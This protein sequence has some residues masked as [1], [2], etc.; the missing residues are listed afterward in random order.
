MDMEFDTIYLNGDNNLMNFPIATE[1]ESLEPRFKVRL[2]E[3]EFKHLMFDV[4]DV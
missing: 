2:I 1:G 3:K 4:K